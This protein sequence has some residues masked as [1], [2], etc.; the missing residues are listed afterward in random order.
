MPDVVRDMILAKRNYHMT[1]AEA[2]KPYDK[3][4]NEARK[5]REVALAK[6]GDPRDPKVWQAYNEST[7]SIRIIFEET[8]NPTRKLRDALVERVEVMKAEGVKLTDVH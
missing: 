3:G 2:W 6:S 8:I 4:V 5:I 1:V 7:L